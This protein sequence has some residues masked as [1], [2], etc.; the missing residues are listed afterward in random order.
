MKKFCVIEDHYSEFPD[1]ITFKKGAILSVGER[2][3]GPEDWADWV[4]CTISGQSG[5]WVPLQL[6][7]KTSDDSAV[8]LEDYTARELN[9]RK[10]DMLLGDRILNGWIWCT[11]PDQSCSG[12][13]P[14]EKLCDLSNR[15][16]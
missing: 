3:E 4:F 12:W 13:V 9:V 8:A 14:Q 7:D 10:N 11:T 16:V 6:L 1:P 5:G 15:L 2:Y